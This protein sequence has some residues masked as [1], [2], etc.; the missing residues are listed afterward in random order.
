MASKELET[1]IKIDGLMSPSLK[2]SIT[3]AEEK[4]QR[5]RKETGAN[6]SPLA[7][8]TMRLREQDQQMKALKEQYGSMAAEGRLNSAEAS[9]LKEA[10]QKLNTEMREDKAKVSAARDAVKELDRAMGTAEKDVDRLGDESKQSTSLISRLSQKMREGKAAGKGMSG[11]FKAAAAAGNQ[12][13]G[14]IRSAV[15]ALTAYVSIKGIADAGKAIEEAG[16]ALE[17]SIGGV[18][19]LFGNDSAENAKQYAE[20]TGKSLAVATKEFQRNYKAQKEVLANADAAWRTAGM[21]S[22]EYMQSATMLSA[23]LISGLGGD[24]VKAAEKVDKALKQMSD[25]SNKMGT[26]IENVKNAYK[27]FSKQSYAMLD[28]LS[29]GYQGS[30]SEMARLVND[31]KVL[32][33]NIKVDAKSVKDVPLDKIIDAVGVIQDKLKITGATQKEAEST[34][35]G[36]LN[37]LKAAKENMMANLAL[38]RDTESSYAALAESAKNYSTNL[39]DMVKRV[40][41]QMP[42][43]IKALTGIDLSKLS[44]PFQKVKAAVVEAF[45]PI[46]KLF[47]KELPQ[48]GTEKVTSGITAAL[49]IVEKAIERMKPFVRNWV[50]MMHAVIPALSEVG[51]HIQ[52]D[53]LPVLMSIQDKVVN[54]LIPKVIGMV[55]TLI[56]AIMKIIPVIAS[57]G[58]TVLQVAGEV[59]GT[60]TDIVGAA[61]GVIASVVDAISAILPAIESVIQAVLPIVKGK[62]RNALKIVGVILTQL[63]TILGNISQRIQGIFRDSE[64]TIGKLTG[65]LG[66]VAGMVSEIV[67]IIGGDLQ[68]TIAEIMPVIGPIVDEVMNS[69]EVIMD[70]VRV[71]LPAIQNAIATIMPLI[72]KIIKAVLPVVRKLATAIVQLVGKQVSFIAGMIKAIVP[73][74]ANILAVIIPIVTTCIDVI[75][76]IITTIIEIIEAVLPPVIS[77]V[78][79]IISTSISIVTRIISVIGSILGAITSAVRAC[80]TPI[81]GFVRGVVQAVKAVVSSIV[82]FVKGV[83]GKV[84]AALQAAISFGR[85]VVGKIRAGVVLVKTII[86]GIVDKIRNVVSAI[87]TTMRNVADTIK[88][89]FINAFNAAKNII[90][91]FKEKLKFN[92]PKFK[93]PHFKLQGGEAPFGLMGKGSLPK[94]DVQWYAKGGIMTKPTIFGGGEAGD[95][96]V[97]PLKTLWSKMREVIADVIATRQEASKN[98]QV[99]VNPAA[100]SPAQVQVN[101]AAVNPPT[102]QVSPAAVNPPPVQVSPAAVNPPPVQVNPAAVNPPPVQVS[103]AAASPTPVQVSPAELTQAPVQPIREENIGTV[104]SLIGKLITMKDFS[105]GEIAGGSQG[106]GTVVYDFS[107]MTWA[108]T[109]GV[110]DSEKK[111]EFMDELRRHEAE[112]VQWLIDMM[113]ARR[114]EEYA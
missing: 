41:K 45:S 51:K 68:K 5:L 64:G 107:K 100:V 105:L 108:P 99:Q 69:V 32:G 90:E 42:V 91:S 58:T 94:L 35:Q 75:I 3:E 87:K 18:E 25:N 36:S 60:L 93:L 39:W 49:K 26:D 62:I 4:L 103:P 33:E 73:V 112:F 109:I 84:G 78:S 46:K 44:E 24:T 66:M 21:S 12:L 9:K 56:P 53:L 43:V 23:S 7:K 86:G 74:I 106:S 92:I 54:G 88:A 13:K 101:P 52:Q 65:V 63:G 6:A 17:Q 47:P 19:T 30:A 34:L 85:G 79:G 15:G 2:K 31:S 16:G 111:E 61:G 80:V 113:R 76:S 67:D 40:G 14:S 72:Q 59:L 98:I 11:G 82:G 55:R 38:G 28:N 20:A 102:V 95:E 97:L 57:I 83:T 22:D 70:A 96:A 48:I 81:I 114:E 29:L 77:I 89:P 71:I 104:Q 8:L 10:I 27:G 1:V 37:S 50:S 110:Q